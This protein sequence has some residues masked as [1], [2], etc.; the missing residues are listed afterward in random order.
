MRTNI[1][2]FWADERSNFKKETYVLDGLVRAASATGRR[3]EYRGKVIR[4]FRSSLLQTLLAATSVEFGKDRTW[5]T[6]AQILTLD[7]SQ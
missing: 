4:A 6:S 7:R 3:L 2:D 5:A 1:L